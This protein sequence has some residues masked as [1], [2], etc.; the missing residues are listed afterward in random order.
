MDGQKHVL[1]GKSCREWREEDKPPWTYF[2]CSWK[3]SSFMILCVWF[4]ASPVFTMNKI[5]QASLSTGGNLLSI[6]WA[7][8]DIWKHWLRISQHLCISSEW[9]EYF[10]RN[11][12]KPG[13]FQLVALA[14]K[15]LHIVFSRCLIAV[16]FLSYYLHLSGNNKTTTGITEYINSRGAPQTNITC[17]STGNSCTLSSVWVMLSDRSNLKHDTHTSYVINTA[18]Q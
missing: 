5:I 16:T 14:N 8:L 3:S 9:H 7:L 11:L 10:D 12:K 15:L 6:L 4:H 1:G 13:Q 2:G 17:N 18:K